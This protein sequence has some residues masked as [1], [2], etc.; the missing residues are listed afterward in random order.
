MPAATGSPAL[1]LEGTVTID[2]TTYTWAELTL[3]DAEEF[4]TIIG[5]LLDPTES[6]IDRVTGRVY[7]TYLALRKHHPNLTHGQIREWPLS[8]LG[9]MWEIISKA[10]PF[11]SEAQAAPPSPPASSSESAPTDSVGPQTSPEASDSA[12]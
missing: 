7:L 1:R 3:T 6:K 12:T 10:I 9:A 5:P 2:G 4:E 11:L 8:A